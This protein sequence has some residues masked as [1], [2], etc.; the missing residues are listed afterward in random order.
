MV[1]ASHSN[2][3]ATRSRGSPF[4]VVPWAISN[5]SLFKMITFCILVL[6]LPYA[7]KKRLFNFLSESKRSRMVSKSHLCKSQPP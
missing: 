4:L 2:F 6:P 7:F 3:P 5:H 1:M